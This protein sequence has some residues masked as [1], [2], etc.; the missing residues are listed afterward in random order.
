MDYPQQLK[1]INHCYV[2]L[3]R[4]DLKITD[5]TLFECMKQQGLPF[6]RI[7]SGR[8]VCC[9]SKVRARTTRIATDRYEIEKN[10][11]PAEARQSRVSSI[12][13]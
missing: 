4:S 13:R 3:V 10:E 11:I 2:S 12:C 9:A 7:A 6:A 1:A 5:A 8:L